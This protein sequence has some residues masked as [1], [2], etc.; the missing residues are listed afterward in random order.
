[1]SSVITIFSVL[2]MPYAY[3]ARQQRVGLE[4]VA[5]PGCVVP[6]VAVPVLL[7]RGVV[8]AECYPFGVTF[9]CVVFDAE[10]YGF[11]AFVYCRIAVI[12]IPGIELGH[13]QSSG[14]TSRVAVGILCGV[15][16]QYILRYILSAT[17][18]E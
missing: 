3:L 6:I 15:P 8:K 2:F 12:Y 14:V 1:M 13:L 10:G 7:R 5:S 16:I 17:E 9:L 18:A 4:G 11:F